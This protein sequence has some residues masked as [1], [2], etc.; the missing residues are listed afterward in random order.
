MRDRMG[1]LRESSR[2]GMARVL[3]ALTVAL[4]FSTAARAQDAPDAVGQDEVQ[5]GPSPEV[6]MITPE[7]PEGETQAQEQGAGESP[8]EAAAPTGAADDGWTVDLY[9][10]NATHFRGKDATG[11]TV[12]LSKFR[13]TLQLEAAKKFA[14]TWEF[15]AILRGTWDGVYSLNKD[16]YGKRAG[17]SSGAE[18]ALQSTVAGQR[19]T[20]PYGSVASPLVLGKTAVDGVLGLLGVPPVSA[21]VDQYSAASGV[22]LRTLGDRWHNLDGGVSFGVPVRPCNIDSRGCRNFGGY[23]NKSSSGLAFSEFNNRLDFL[24]E[25]YI[26]GTM[27]LGESTDL[28]LKLGR[29]QVVWGRTDLFR[30]LDVLNPVDYS[31]NNIYDELEDIRIPQWMVQAEFRFGG[32]GPF[33][34][35]NLQIVW[36]FDK[37]RPNNLGQCGSPNSILDAGCFFRGMANLWDNGGTVSN[38]AHLSSPVANLAGIPA[39]SWF[40]TNFGPGQ[41]G[42]RNVNLPKWSLGNT[43]IGA[44]FEGV[45]SNGFN[46]S[47]NAL[48]FR[49][50]LPSLRSFN[51]AQHPFLG[52][53]PFP[54]SYLIAFDLYYPR[55]K[56]FGA[57][58]DF[59]SEA[60]GAAFRFEGAYTIGEEFPNTARTALYSKNNVLRTVLGID[61]P[62]FIPFINPN[63]TTLISAQIFWQH[64]FDHERHQGAFGAYGM[65]DWKD[66][67][68]ITLLVKAFLMQDRLSPQIIQ[69]Y[70]MKARA[71][72][73]SP[74][75]DWIVNDKLTFSLGA[76]V[77]ATGSKARW[78]FNDCRDC[79]PY[80]PFTAYDEHGA[81]PGAMG[82]VGLSGLEPL[83]RFRAG[84]I[85]A[86]T[87]EDEIYVSLRFNY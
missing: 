37:F 40:A 11:D 59:Q 32:G 86:A 61:R 27:S 76:N 62:T 80:P 47:L 71:Y 66:D 49:S 13:N 2:L 50:Q 78:Q 31:R 34:E 25:V 48:F 56:L 5:M 26:K 24:R 58:A 65:P 83:G 6:I 60:L 75:I 23:G 87:R 17:S 12:G 51:S 74:Q 9:Y 4:P 64:I 38:F 44:K 57:S 39:D 41:I 1:Y 18:V 22:G 8:A 3:L 14:D 79:N 29:Q 21:F 46:F 84:P 42:L 45:L 77:K 7:A 67:V 52:I 20:A 54:T 16:Q 69:A 68:T 35:R 53:T 73:I 33:A 19:L 85:G 36:N 15:H 30:V 81:F 10:E 63:R 82:A 72:V 70:D 43:Q 28:F 55:V